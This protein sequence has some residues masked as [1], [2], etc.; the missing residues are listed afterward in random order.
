ML[1]RQAIEGAERITNVVRSVRM[2]AHAESR[3]PAP[4]DV[5]AVLES[6]LTIVDH[7]LRARGRVVVELGEVPWVMADESA[8]GQVFLA[9]LVNA[10]QAL[11]EAGGG[12]IRVRTSTDADG[13]AVIE[14]EDTGA[15]IPEHLLPRIFE[16]FFTTR[17]VGQGSGL[18]LSVSQGIVSGLGGRIE[19][20]SAVG[21]GTTMRVILPPGRRTRAST[22]VEA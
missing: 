22:G 15:G 3:P 21:R 6:A 16:P 4:L 7:D 17:P 20:D 2:L 13:D 8:L 9:L 18:G 1:L 12:E 10:V 5:R 14:I 11:P 19:V